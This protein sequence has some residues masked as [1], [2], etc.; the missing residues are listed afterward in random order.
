ML[1]PTPPALVAPA[2]A[3]MPDHADALAEWLR[4]GCEVLR[5]Y[6]PGAEYGLLLIHLGDGVPDVQLPVTPPLPLHR[7]T[8]LPSSEQL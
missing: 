4:L 7:E 3:P 8:S 6:Y 5:C 1:L 2:P